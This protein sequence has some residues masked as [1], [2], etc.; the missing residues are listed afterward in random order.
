[1]TQI[2]N[3]LNSLI[4][5]S[6][7]K[8]TPNSK[9][10]NTLSILD[11]YQI[12][13]ELLNICNLACPLCARSNPEV[14][15]FIK[16]SGSKHLDLNHLKSSLKLF[17]NLKKV[18][19]VGGICEPTLYKDF[20]PL[21]I[22]LKENKYS[23]MISTNAST[24]T[25][26][27]WNEIGTILKKDDEI[28]FAID[29]STQERY[30][31]YR[32]NG[33]LEKIIKNFKAFSHSEAFKV[34]QVIKF[35]HN[36]DYY[37]DDIQMIQSLC[38]NKFDF[39]YRLNTGSEAPELGLEYPVSNKRK[40]DFY[41]K[42]FKSSN[43]KSIESLSK[44]I[45]CYS[46]LGFIYINH[47]G[48]FIP[49]CDRYEEFLLEETEVAKLSRPSIYNLTNDNLDLLIDYFNLVYEQIPNSELC[50][51][52]CHKLVQ[53]LQEPDDRIVNR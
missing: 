24:L 31:K 6:N 11:V 5:G 19:L 52:Y 29:G 16:E 44:D 21:L 33:N 18:H 2:D 34:L 12:E 38:D 50:I 43:K 40:I 48:N 28:R 3:K 41:Q 46:R 27:H 8:I 39:V 53:L 47:L 10:Q 42:I 49:C 23:L 7:R 30:H 9:N 45:Y 32:I 37:E 17:P 51:R 36:T 1:M 22:W 35:K 25:E 4:L 13:I 15:K 26:L 14:K 20:I